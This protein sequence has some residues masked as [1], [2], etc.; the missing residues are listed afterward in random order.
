[1]N[2]RSVTEMRLR[3]CLRNLAKFTAIIVKT[4]TL[5][6]SAAKNKTTTTKTT[7]KQHQQREN[8]LDSK[9]ALPSGMY[10]SSRSPF[11]N[12]RTV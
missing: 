2:A 7:T 6:V 12:R 8:A 11:D 10:E 3:W 4:Y 9:K 5:F 1:M